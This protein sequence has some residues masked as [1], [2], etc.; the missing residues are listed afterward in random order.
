MRLQSGPGWTLL[1]CPTARAT[2]AAAVL[3]A[4][5]G[6]ASVVPS[7]A[8][9]AVAAHT[10]PESPS[11]PG[12]GNAPSLSPAQDA[13]VQAELSL[14]RLET[15]AS[16]AAAAHRQA[17]ARAAAARQTATRAAAHVRVAKAA[18]AQAE[19]NLGRLAA[20]AYRY[21]PAQGAGALWLMLDV[22]DPEQ[23]LDGVHLV[24]RVLVHASDVVAR[25]RASRADADAA[26]ARATAAAA[27]SNEA[28][29][30]VAR[31]A[32]AATDAANAAEARI[33]ALGAR[34]DG[35]LGRFSPA[36]E[37]DAELEAEAESAA[38]S[39][40][41]P[42]VPY[43]ADRETAAVSYALAQ[44]GKPY[45]WGGTG[46]QAFDC[47][48]LAMRAY[49]AAG[50]DLPHFAASQYAASHPLTY[51]QLR[52]GDLLFWATDPHDARTIYHEAV[53]LG[54]QQ[55]V[56]APKTGWNVMVSDMWMWGPIQ[57]YARP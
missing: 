28:E 12:H 1:T 14:A 50:V 15:A 10:A 47:S 42:P 39:A 57:F 18:D 45:L 23:Y 7:A 11:V 24:R 6:H 31:S 9:A 26:N 38:D 56:Q 3:L 27:A 43:D 2:L 37:Q 19:S 33:A 36:Q 51:R 34:L 13:L 40:D 54:G 4:C 5:A 52:P 55:M 20:A 29:Q 48:G 35:E 21:G 32:K 44:L 49:Q 25:A 8:P 46:P 53:Y 22:G 16:Q 30:A 41:A 17:S